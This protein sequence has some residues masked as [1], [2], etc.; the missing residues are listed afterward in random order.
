MSDDEADEESA[1]GR[2][3]ELLASYYG[4]A[5]TQAPEDHSGDINSPSF[6]PEAF[7]RALLRD[8]KQEALL[9]RDEEMVQEVKKLDSDMQM[10]VYE[11]YN[12]F[13]SATDTIRKMKQN[14]E[15]MEAEMAS[16]QDSMEKISAASGHVSASLADK[17]GKVDTLVRVRRLLSR[18]A[19]L[20]DLPEILRAAAEKGNAAQ[21]IKYYS[22]T[23]GILR[24]HSHVSSFGAILRETEEIMAGLRARLEAKVDA[25]GV[26]Q[27][28]A[29][30]SNDVELLRLLSLSQ[31]IP[32]FA[33]A[34]ETSK[35]LQCA[36]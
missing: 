36:V 7:V 17:R 8:G 16:L 2:M 5:A 14:V 1:T 31:V 29:F 12:K 27:V 22:M 11:N 34:D 10:L 32:S 23:H 20:F 9:R 6:D 21:A 4:I 33:C 24:K 3:S 19:F 13:I 35:F 25:P 28:T 18:L 26:S 15:S 30:L